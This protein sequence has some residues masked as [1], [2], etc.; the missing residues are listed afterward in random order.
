[1][2]ADA[3]ECRVRFY[4]NLPRVTHKIRCGDLV[5]GRVW[6]DGTIEIDDFASVTEVPTAEPPTPAH[7]VPR[8]TDA[9]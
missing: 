1:M 6:S 8:M 2:S 3:I 4:V 7:Q 5:V 9:P